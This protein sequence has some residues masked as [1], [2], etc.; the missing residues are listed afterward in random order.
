M[1]QKLCRRIVLTFCVSI[2]VAFALDVVKN[3]EKDC[4]GG[5]AG[6]C[7]D[8]GNMYDFGYPFKQDYKKAAELYQKACNGGNAL[9]CYNL[10]LMYANGKGVKQNKSKAK[11]L[12]GDACDMG[13]QGGC[14]A[15]REL[16]EAGVQ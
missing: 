10:G 8:L 2:S 15:Y 7:V 5:N 9:G 4:N 16:N 13:E 1:I 14:D 12:F 6:A 11:K 3:L